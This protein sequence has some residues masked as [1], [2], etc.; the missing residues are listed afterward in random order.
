MTA[1][2]RISRVRREY[3]Q[4]VANETLEDYSLRFTAK[5]ARK[6]SCLR[7]ANTALGSISFLALEAIGAAITLSYGFSNAALAIAVVG[8]MIFLTGLPISYYAA[9]Y[10]IDM[11]L[12]TRGAGFG[13]I[14]STVTSLIY[15]SFTFI[16]FAIEAVILAMA[17]QLCFGI[18]LTLGYLISALAVIPLVTHGITLISRFQVWTQPLWV[19][20]SLLPVLFIAVKAPSELSGWTGFGGQ[21]GRPGGGWSLPAFGAAASVAFALIAQIGEQVDFL[22][23][24]PPRQRAGKL[25]WWA[26]LLTAGPGWIV[27]GVLKMFAGSLL[28]Y[29]ALMH[30]TPLD[31]AV[32]PTQMYLIGFGYVFPAPQVAVW[33][34]GLFVVIS[35]LKINVTNAY[36]GSIAWSNFFSRL[37]HSH[38][39]RVVWLVFNVLLALLLMGLGVFHALEQ[40]LGWYSNV[41]IAWIGALVADLVVNKPLGLSPRHIEFKRAYLYDVNPVGVGAMLVASIVSICAFGGMFGEVLRALA[42]FLAFGVAFLA[43]PV[44]AFATGGRYYSARPLDA[45]GNRTEPLRCCICENHFEPEDMAHCPAYAGPICSLCCSLDVRCEDS[46]KTRS[47]VSEQLLALLGR[48]LPPRVMTRLDSSLGHYLGVFLVVTACLGAVLYLLYLQEATLPSS[49]AGQIRAILWKVFFA[50]ALIAGVTSWLLVLA[51]QSRKVAQEESLRQTQLLMHEI[52]AHKR[53]DAQLQKAKEAAEAANLAK[54]RYVT[55]ISHEL[56]TPLNSVLGYAQLLQRD[57]GIPPRR[58]DAIEVIRRSGEHLAG[59]IDG[60]L[61]IAKIEAGRLHLHRGEVFFRDLLEQVVKMFS[62]QAAA[63]GLQFHFEPDPLLPELVYGDERRLRQILINLLS[64]AIKFTE[65]GHVTLRVRYRRQLAEFEVEDSGVGI[66]APDLERVFMPFERGRGAKSQAVPGTGLGLT[67]SKLLVE[68]MGGQIQVQSKVG[69]GSTFHFTLMLSQVTTPTVAR[70][71]QKRVRG[72]LGPRKT[73]MAVDDEPGHRD[74]IAE[75]LEPLG[76]AVVTAADHAECQALGH[77]MPVDLFLLDVNLPG[78]NGW[79][80]A[81]RLRETERADAPI[82]MVSANAYESQRGGPQGF[83][84]DYIV[85][86]VDFWTL[87]EKIRHHLQI[88][89]IYEEPEAA[90]LEAALPAVDPSARDHLEALWSLGQMGHVRGIHHKLDEMEAGDAAAR[91]L[92]VHLRPLVKGFQLNRYMKIL[93]ELRAHVA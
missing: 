74:L 17:L 71:A 80:L 29:L 79:E 1:V 21:Y 16:F 70:G 37:T 51:Q 67:I 39:G 20:L 32:E 87:L 2:Q 66:A 14:G 11:D 46:C 86:P 85:K 12:L 28:A 58:R 77:T 38:P 56:R 24:L 5:S 93:E 68:I 63:K 42:P 69:V 22:R 84:D 19:V 91:A 92:A 72:Y 23:F 43:A 36:A 10:G 52:E 73:V 25:Q 48:F 33:V 82:V 88:E 47:R 8:A 57:D 31:R 41:A 83:H 81:R 27:I 35:Q 15:A 78:V 53:T 7:V 49:E 60:L 65:Q 6:W 90:P 50:F 64:N 59:L 30:G 54:S 89:W 45:E 26:A 55:S 18:P 4:F 40:V 34:T 44:I 75:L 9:R 13:Y 61:D 3:N 62:L 76:F